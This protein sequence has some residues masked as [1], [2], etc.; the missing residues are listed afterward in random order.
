MAYSSNDP[1]SPYIREQTWRSRWGLFIIGLVITIVLLLLALGAGGVFRPFVL[2]ALGCFI[3]APAI[4]SIVATFWFVATRRA[5]ESAEPPREVIAR[6]VTPVT[7]VSSS[8][9][10]SSVSQK[11]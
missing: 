2:G 6:I 7:M 3:V 10:E 5:L 11:R 9:E 8:G 1:A 4:F